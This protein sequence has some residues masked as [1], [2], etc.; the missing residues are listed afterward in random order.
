MSNAELIEFYTTK[1]LNGMDF[2]IMRK[3]MERKEVEPSIIKEVIWEIDHQML[4]LPKIEKE[5]NTAKW[6][7]SL[8]IV[9]LIIPTLFL[10]YLLVDG[11]E[12]NTRMFLIVPIQLIA[13][14]TAKTK[15]KRA[16]FNRDRKGL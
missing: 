10:V 4:I 14:Y 1:R 7:Y 13:F 9:F 16:K 11:E 3:D 8:S 5:Y 12:L 2:S 15:F 6:V